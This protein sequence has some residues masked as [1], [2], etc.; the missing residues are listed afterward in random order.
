MSSR[1]NPFRPRLFRVQESLP[2]FHPTHLPSIISQIERSSAQRRNETRTSI[3]IIS[4]IPV[5]VEV[6]LCLTVNP[7]V[8]TGHL[9]S[10]FPNCICDD[11]LP[12]TPASR[13]PATAVVASPTIGNMVASENRNSNYSPPLMNASFPVPVQQTYQVP[14][15]TNNN[16]A[17]NP[18][19]EEKVKG[20]CKAQSFPS[21]VL[22]PRAQVVAP[23]AAV[24][25]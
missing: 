2:K 5:V 8:P 12:A 1:A 10:D 25:W 3:S 23:L 14:P 22:R 6:W 17:N 21:S 7:S 11:G 19:N 24:P 20:L 18:A 4:E 13:R 9:R 16:P 15:P